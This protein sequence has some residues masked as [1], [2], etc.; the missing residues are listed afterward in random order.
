MG[1]DLASEIDRLSWLA[2]CLSSSLGCRDSVNLVRPGVPPEPHCWVQSCCHGASNNVRS[3]A[4]APSPAVQQRKRPVAV[5]SPVDFESPGGLAE[6]L[7]RLERIGSQESRT[8]MLLSS[9]S[10]GQ[11]VFIT[12][13][14]ARLRGY[15]TFPAGGLDIHR[16]GLRRHPER[17]RQIQPQ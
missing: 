17:H 7:T 2:R 8:E 4:R 15:L 10:R 12:C 1:K 5:F 3:S 16:P 14:R 13:F 9:L 11:K 6:N